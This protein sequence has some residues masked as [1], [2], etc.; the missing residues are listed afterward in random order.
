[1]NIIKGFKD[2]ADMVIA[3]PDLIQ[4]ANDMAAE[5]KQM[6]ASHGAAPVAAASVQPADAAIEPIAGVDLDL[7]VKISKGIAGYGYDAAMLPTVASSFGVSAANWTVASVGWAQ[8]IQ[9]NPSVG[10]RFNQL[11]TAI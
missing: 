1:M 5:A 3:A 7:Y 6:Q 4:S 9:A 8:R 2:M 11:Y 10:A